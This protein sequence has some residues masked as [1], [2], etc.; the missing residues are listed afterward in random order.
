MDE[1]D[2]DGGDQPSVVDETFEV[3]QR[4]PF[5]FFCNIFIGNSISKFECI[6]I[7]FIKLKFPLNLLGRSTNGS[8]GGGAG[9]DDN[10]LEIFFRQQQQRG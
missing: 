6:Q 3:M 7:Y 8:A 9:T 4:G 10:F 1:Q 5:G 2:A